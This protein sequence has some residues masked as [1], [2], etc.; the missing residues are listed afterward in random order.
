M[1]AAYHARD[2]GMAKEDIIHLIQQI[3]DYWVG[4]FPEDRL[5]RPSYHKSGDSSD[6]TYARP[7]SITREDYPALSNRV[8]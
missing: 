1:R 4:G 2:L 6:T 7:I 5:E 8:R 3:V